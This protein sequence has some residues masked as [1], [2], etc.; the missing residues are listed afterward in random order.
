M[1]LRQ[2]KASYDSTRRQDKASYDSMPL[3]SEL[4][5]IKWADVQREQRLLP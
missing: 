2:D 4:S 5:F 3:C 1:T